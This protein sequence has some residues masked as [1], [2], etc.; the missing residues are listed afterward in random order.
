MLTIQPKLTNYQAPVFKASS[1]EDSYYREKIAN[2][3]NKQKEFDELL[4]E[5]AKAPKAFK[6]AIKGFKVISEVLLQGWAL[7]WGTKKGAKVVKSSILSGINSNTVP[8]AKN[9][10]QPAID[11]IEKGFKYT[12]EFFSTKIQKIKTSEFATNLNGKI[13]NII[14]KMNNN[15][16]GKYIVKGFEYIGK[17][18]KYIG[19]L[20]KQGYEW[21]TKP[22]KGKTAEEVYDKAA[23][24]TASTL[25]VGAGATALY[26]ETANLKPQGDNTETLADEALETEDLEDDIP[27]EEV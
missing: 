13:T 5:N 22:F 6:A 15:P 27:E 20:I 25:G 19:N 26:N 16:I 3:K 17:G 7:A 18:F 24:V 4:D 12:K 10:V 21:F 23:S 8:K 1:D 11:L 2:Y 9:F 14:E